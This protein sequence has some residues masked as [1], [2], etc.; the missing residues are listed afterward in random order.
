[1]DVDAQ[2]ELIRQF[3]VAVAPQV[4]V[5]CLGNELS[6]TNAAAFTLEAS[7]QLAARYNELCET[8]TAPPQDP[9]SP[10]L[11]K[12]GKSTEAIHKTQA[13]IPVAKPEVSDLRS[14]GSRRPSPLSPDW[15]PPSAY[16]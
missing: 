16:E 1:M 2:S 11:Q 3:M 4:I 8:L 15:R 5:H 12:A 14:S 10:Q 7:M 13:R 6:M 9:A